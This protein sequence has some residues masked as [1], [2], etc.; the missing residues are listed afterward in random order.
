MTKLNA[1]ADNLGARPS[2]KRLGRGIGS[3]KGKTAGRG[4]KGQKARSGTSGVR[5]FEGGQ[6]P[7]YR[8]LNKIG[9]FNLFRKSFAEINIGKIE[10][11]I[12][13]KKLAADK[14]I[15]IA[16]LQAA[17]LI[18]RAEGGLKVLGAGEIKKAI[19]VEAV[20]WSKS[21]EAA[22]K[23]AGGSIA[24]PAKKDAANK[25]EKTEKKPAAK[26]S[27]VKKTKKA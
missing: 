2:K 16:A 18:N 15:D 17:K 3:G 6:T 25:A 11:A 19:K 12:E 4:H 1:L 26:K 14:V 9:F 10:K 20:K 8:R 7:I 22:I 23:K 21:A 27:A 24:Q 5:T 13:D